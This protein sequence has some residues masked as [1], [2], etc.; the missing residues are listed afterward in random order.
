[1]SDGG[2]RK[3]QQWTQHWREAALR[4]L[5]D[6]GATDHG[7]SSDHGH[8]GNSSEHVGLPTLTGLVANLA[9]LQILSGRVASVN[10]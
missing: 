6:S 7:A 1:M 3:G 9:L 5:G 10:I 8:G 2:S 4:G